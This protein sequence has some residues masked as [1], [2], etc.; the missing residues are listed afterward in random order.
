[1][2]G[3]QKQYLKGLAHAMKPTVLIGQKGLQDAVQNA[4]ETALNTHELIKIKYI[5]LK[6]RDLKEEITATIVKRTQAERVAVI[7][8]TVILYRRQKDPKKRKIQLPD[9]TQQ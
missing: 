5:D 8:H 3:Y 2:Q 1:M 4:I 6:E 7:G 9:R